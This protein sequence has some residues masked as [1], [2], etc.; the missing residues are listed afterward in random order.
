MSDATQRLVQNM[1]NAVLRRDFYRL[2]TRLKKAK[3]QQ[4]KATALAEIEQAHQQ[5]QHRN[6]QRPKV[7]L[8]P[9]LPVS[10]QAD[11]IRQTIIENQVTIIAGET[12]SGKTTQIPK[13]CLQAGLGQ[14]GQIG[15]TQPRR[16]AAKSVAARVSEELAVTLGHGVGYQVRFDEKYSEDG[17]I[18]FMTDGILLQQTLRD[19]WLNDYD[20]IIIDE[21]HERSLNI[22]FLLGFIKKLLPKRPDL[23]VIITSATID[24]E[25]FSAHFNDAPIINVSGR[26]YP[27]T[28]HYRPP[29]E[30]GIDLEEAIIRAVDE[31]Y[32]LKKTGDI[33]V[34]LPGEREINDTI[35]RIKKKHLPNTEV[36]PLYARLTG[37]QQMQ[38]FYPGD[39]RRII[40]STNVAETS[41]TVPRIHCVIDSGL[42]R[43]SRYSARSKIQGLQI[44][45]IAQDSADQRQGRCGRIAPGHCYRL[46]SEADYDSRPEHSDAEILRTS[47]ASV[48]LQTQVLQL[49]DLEDFPFIDSPDFKQIADGYQLLFEL[50]AIDEGRQLTKIG[51]IMA[52]LPIDVQ[53]ARILLAAHA[54]GCLQDIVIMVSMLAVQD[55]RE[56]PLDSSQAADKAHEKYLDEDSDFIGILNLWRILNK[57]RKELGNKKFRDWCRKNF[58]S[59]KK[60]MEW[61]DVH[62]QLLQLL[63]KQ[64]M[65]A[66]SGQSSSASQHEAILSGFISHIGQFHDERTYLGTRN[67]KFM[68]FPGSVLFNRMPKWVVAAE[69]VHTSQV[70]ARMAAQVTVAQIIN[71]GSHLIKHSYYDPYWSKKQGS[72]MGYRRSTILGL[73]LTERERV[74]YGPQ[75]PET[76]RQLFIEQ[77]L[78]ARQLNTRME[79]YRHN[80][81]IIAEI[82]AEEDRHRKRDL[83]IEPAEVYRLYDDRIPDG[84]YSEPQLKKWLKK[85]SGQPLHFTADDFYQNQAQTPEVEQFPDHIQ[86]RQLNIPL[87][88]V[89][90]PDQSDDGVTA[91]L[92]LAWINALNANDFAFLVPGLL[93]EKVVALIKGLPKSLR[94]GLI[95]VNH[96]ADIMTELLDLKKDF[97]QQLVSIVHQKNGL[98]TTV[99]EW[100]AAE[101]PPHLQFRYEVRNH[102]N[103]IVYQGRSFDEMQGRHKQAANVSFQKSASETRQINGAKDWVFEIIEPVV[104][105][106]NGLP[107]YPAVVDQTDAVGLRFFETQEQAAQEHTRGIKR[108]LQ[109]KYPKIVK[110][111]QKINPNLKAALAWDSLGTE[112]KYIDAV[113]DARLEAGIAAGDTVRTQADFDQLAQH[114]SSNLYRDVYQ[115]LEILNQ[116]L[117]KWYETWQAIE[118]HSES[119]ADESYDDMIQELDYL[120]Y[121]GFLRIVSFSELKHYP[122]YLEAL[123]MRLETAL[124]SPQKEAD[125]LAQLTDVS[126]PFYTLC[127]NAA[128]FTPAHQDYLMT[129]QEYRVSLFAQS[130]GTQQKVS[131]KRLRNLLKQ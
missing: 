129:L 84:I 76:S 28:T 98:E 35:E 19:R 13:I 53:L 67:K 124:H 121:D 57:T 22:D 105:L 70:Y 97:Y 128:A 21:A 87:T 109:L 47:L 64:K 52:H 119:L 9:D 108:L 106:D 5:F 49:G 2:S 122:R 61:K 112:N 114:L 14:F 58:I 103:K 30:L 42:A 48:I 38:I 3:N 116:V 81:R 18:R 100:Q 102:N 62:R 104:T 55:P 107:A 117:I 113:I 45:A 65:V 40:V 79:F 6:Q 63:K 126:K 54:L 86:I 93:Q 4:Q 83:L 59:I 17:Y 11:N 29:E 31:F 43:I 20:T 120:I 99:E 68:L 85:Q 72:V 24:T 15:C 82:E 44:E 88:Y 26:S 23:K 34:F 73:T 36:L 7:T 56:R 130:L 131:G 25:K 127:E 66:K 16:I 75:D 118:H 95:P 74:H 33:L 90:A 50:Q 1:Q 39:K 78:V 115:W 27:V 8:A 32:Q 41:L 60:Y 12:G 51:R 10:E 80:S 69:I 94:R 46:Y 96:Y 89:F 71:A 111:C 125:K 123:A 92:K 37:A 110:Q 101:L 77:G 91:H